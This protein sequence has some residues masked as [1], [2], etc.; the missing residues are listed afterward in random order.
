L[1]V[2]QN[3]LEFADGNVF[4]IF[5]QFTNRRQFGAGQFRKFL[6]RH[7]E[8]D[9]EADELQLQIL[10]VLAQFICI[11][12]FGFSLLHS[13]FEVL[14]NFHPVHP[15][16]KIYVFSIMFYLYWK[17]ANNSSQYVKLYIYSYFMR[18]VMV[19]GM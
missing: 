19:C 16:P 2:R 7:S 5:I 3:G 8:A 12:L 4:D 15:P 10:I 11:G 17:N 18:G 14:K 13:V 9:A 6:L 1:S